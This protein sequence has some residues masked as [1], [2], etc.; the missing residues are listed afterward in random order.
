MIHQAKQCIR[1]NTVHGTV[2]LVSTCH[3][4]IHGIGCQY[5]ITHCKHHEKL[6]VNTYMYLDT[7]KILLKIR[8][9]YSL[10]KQMKL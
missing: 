8:T 3:R 2:P 7:T 1:V 9:N 5:C 10:A 6:Q 4:L